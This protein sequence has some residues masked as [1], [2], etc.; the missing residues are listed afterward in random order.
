[1]SHEKRIEILQS[2]VILIGFIL[3]FTLILSLIIFALIRLNA[4]RY[5]SVRPEF[6]ITQEILK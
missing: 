5:K 1:M 4:T 3:S 6:R 2:I